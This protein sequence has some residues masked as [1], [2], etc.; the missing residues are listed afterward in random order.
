MSERDSYEQKP[1]T[2]FQ[3]FAA[4]CL[5]EG[6][7]PK[8]VAFIMDGNRRFA[9]KKEQQLFAG[10]VE[11]LVFL[12]FFLLF[13]IEL[14]DILELNLWVEWQSYNHTDFQLREEDHFQCYNS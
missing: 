3:Q 7:L 9:K 1:L 2:W 10:H 14:Y 13:S 8:H 6:N 12:K 4:N 5:V 11:G